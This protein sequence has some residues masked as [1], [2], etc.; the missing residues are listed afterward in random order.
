MALDL[1]RQQER[2]RTALRTKCEEDTSFESRINVS[3]ITTTESEVAE[4]FSA[5][6][7]NNDYSVESSL[8]ALEVLKAKEERLIAESLRLEDL[9][10]RLKSRAEKL[11][12][13][14][15]DPIAEVL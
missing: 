3:N 6:V 12:R 11:R 14:A 9:A 5:A 2:V 4:A 8:N 15:G 10:S 13:N 7:D 1:V